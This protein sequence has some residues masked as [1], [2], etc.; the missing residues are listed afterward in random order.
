MVQ[1]K[2]LCISFCHGK[3]FK[4]G[5]SWFDSISNIWIGV[6]EFSMLAKID[7]QSRKYLS[8]YCCVKSKCIDTPDG[9]LETCAHPMDLT[10]SPNIYKAVLYAL[11]R[12]MHLFWSVNILNLVMYSPL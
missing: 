5:R 10:G 1:Y 3:V 11:H 7:I 9:I 8:I 12:Y 6:Q 2:S 4:E